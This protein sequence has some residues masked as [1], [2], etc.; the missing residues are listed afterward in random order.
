MSIDEAARVAGGGPSEEEL[1]ASLEESRRR[2]AAV[3]SEVADGIT[4]QRPDGRLVYANVAAA[5]TLG[6]D[7]PE[8][9]L[10]VPPEELLSGFELF[11]E[12]RRPLQPAELPGRLA[13]TGVV[14]AERLVLY[15]LRATG[16]ERWALVRARP[17]MGEDGSVEAA[18]NVFHDISERRRREETVQ[19]VSDAGVLLS[20]T[21]DVEATLASVARLAVPRIADWCIVYMREDDGSI[22]RLAIEH[23]GGDA[24]AVGEVLDRYPLDV[25]A[26]V[27]VPLVV[28]TGQTLLLADV[29]A[30][31]LMA[32]V[33][34]PEGLSAELKH[35]ELA[36]YLCVPLIA[37]GRTL[38]AISLLSSE[39]GR[40]F[41]PDEKE[42]AEQLAG[43]AA[44]AVD[45]G[46]LYREAERAAARERQRSEQLLR[47]SQAALLVNAAGDLDELLAVV[48]TRAR[49]IVGA[50]SAVTTIEAAEGEATLRAVAGHGN[51]PAESAFLVAP[52][53]A[54]DG[55]TL[56]SIELVG[57]AAD[58]FSA[59]DEAI[60]VQLAQMASVAVEN[61]RAEAER[62]RLVAELRSQGALLEAVLRQLPSGVII[63][64]PDGGVVMSNDQASE[65][66]QE[67]FEV[68]SFSRRDAYAGYHPDG[69]Q[70]ETG[71][72]PLARAVEHGES[73]A[74]EEIEIK[75]ADGTRRVIEVSAAPVREGE[76]VIAAVTT[77]SDVTDR[78]RAAQRLRFLAEASTVLGSS[79][80][81]E[82]TLGDV[83]ELAVPAHA[84]WCSIS[85]LEDDGAIKVVSWTHSEP[86]KKRW[87]AEMRQRRQ[88]RLEDATPT[89]E[90]IRN[91]LPVLIRE[92][93]DEV[94]ARYR[95]EDAELAQ[96]MG[97]R[98]V[99][100]VPCTSGAGTLG[101]IMFVSAESGRA[102]DDDDVL[103][104]R[105]L[106]RRAGAAIENARLYRAMEQRARAAEALEFVG[107]GVLLVAG[108]G[109]V[110]LWNPQAEAITGLAV[111]DVEGRPAAEAIPGWEELS[112]LVPVVDAVD[113]LRSR[114]HVVPLAVE[115]AD[116][117][118]AMSGV[119][120]PDGTVYAFRDI[121][122]ERRLERMKS[123]FVSTVSHEL[124]TPL[125]AI[126]G[127][128]LTLRRADM[129]L[130]DDQ[131]QELLAVI[132][133]EADRLARI[134][135]DILWTSRIESG[136][137]QV[138]IES[139]D[140]VELA[141]SVVQAAR[142]HLPAGVALD[143][144][145]GPELRVAA[146]PDKVRQVLA[147][148]VDNAV[149]YSPGG[150]RVEVALVRHNGAI[151]FAVSD[152]GLGIP[153]TERERVFEKFY[154]LDPDL[155]RGVGGTGLGLFICRE[156]ARR[157]DGWIWIEGREPR[158]S[159]VVLELPAG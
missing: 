67:E 134:V 79:L 140:A 115:G 138:Q 24:E 89:A 108:D 158:G 53:L 141:S 116:L 135:N 7:S 12:E 125:A 68:A 26:D 131:R 88:V 97:V 123:D 66:F 65:I 120:F 145:G 94:V 20:S 130:P 80:D 152:E 142:L 45:N 33:V 136:A 14:A 146:D 112:A 147:N 104:A 9:L 75:R 111:R 73:A 23:A 82:R 91:G 5:R 8:E 62:E 13:L 128:A 81:Y 77:F 38:G 119:R 121:T 87:A 137:M 10:A 107:E 72:W 143:L 132:S 52:L 57:S 106:G 122:E 32:D 127:A 50:V 31:G 150:G 110:R 114:S 153:A 1:R 46:R 151:R 98:S 2:L 11:D 55:R 61:F 76:K 101:S 69:R 29:S 86:E 19:F 154:R 105:E 35:I 47:L 25:D 117:W 59:E 74:G 71:E 39:S 17:I 63:A 113:A 96:A 58:P 83:A 41:G 43:R 84:D 129:P 42:L 48:T 124:R 70:Y 27:G 44:L 4:V 100:V 3:L 64:A 40:R 93:T 18:V 139:C 159:T 15:R 60:L 6:Y 78:A 90:V 37:R 16:E 103:L 30:T 157:M 28:R 109:I 118:L 36:S 156:L 92:I 49:E 149:K 102:F 56:G 126:Y 34:D 144:T 85:V 22:R 54:R 95:P 21:L 99:L 155:T 133:D 148:L 51:P